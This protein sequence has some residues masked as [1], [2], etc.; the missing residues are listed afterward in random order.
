MR[1]IVVS[2]IVPVY[3]TEM[4]LKRCADSLMSQT[5]RDFEVVFV[6]D[7]SDDNCPSICDY[8]CQIDKRFKVIHKKNEGLGL[9]RNAGLEVISG[10]YF[11]FLDSDDWLDNDHIEK[12]VSGTFQGKADVVIAGCKHCTEEKVI[13]YSKIYKSGIISEQEIIKDIALPI[14]APSLDEKSELAIPMS[15]CFNL[16]KTSIV[17]KCDIKFL[18]E[19]DTVGEDLFFNLKYLNSSNIINYLDWHGYNYRINE[20]SISRHYNPKRLERTENFY[21]LIKQYIVD[22]GWESKAEYRGERSTLS[23]F[24]AALRLAANSSGGLSYQYRECKRILNSLIL[25]ELLQIYPINEYRKSVRILT[26]FM[27]YK[28]VVLVMLV[29]K[30]EKCFMNKNT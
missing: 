9:A 30:Y 28:L 22:L 7:G 18:S 19:R 21:M 25:Q 6:D 20:N 8:Y 16:Y 26:Y 14:I 29:F 3:R 4:Y 11:T 15:V 12:M 24:R 10:D 1:H 5:F 27:K 2:I 23:K 13:D 17:K